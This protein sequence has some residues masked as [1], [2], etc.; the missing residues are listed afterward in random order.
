ME[1][2]R[3]NKK[4]LLMLVIVLAV[5]LVS[6]FFASMIQSAGYKV[7]VTDLR[8]ATNSGYLINEE[9][10]QA[11]TTEVEG[12]VVSGI[13]FMP[14]DASASNKK[15][16]VVL[17]HG[18]LNNRELQL[19][20]A[21]ELAR[22]G[23][24]VLTIDRGGH[25]NNLPTTDTSAM[26]NTSG[27]YDSVKYLYN[28]P[29]VDKTKIGISGH[30]MGGFTT[31][32][33]LMQDASVGIV[34]AGLMQGWDSF[35]GAGADVSVGILKA[36]DDEFF[37]GSEFPNGEP[38][39][40]R[41]YLHSTGA[42]DF[43]G[44][45]YDENSTI[46]IENGGIYVNGQLTTTSDDGSA[47]GQPFRVIYEANEIHPLNHFSTESAG[48]L[49]DFF[50]KAFGTPDGNDFIAGGNQIWW[51][52]EAFSTIGLAAF[53]VLIFPVV[54]LLLTLPCFASLRKK[55]ELDLDADLPSIKKGGLCGITSTVTYFAGGLA[56]MLFGGFILRKCY[57]EW[58]S[59][60][61]PQGTYFPQDTTGSIMGW[62]VIC[63]A[64]ALT[65]MGVMWLVKAIVAKVASSKG[66]ETLAV[67]N[68]FACARIGISD[69]LK[70]IFLAIVVIALLY[71]VVFINWEIW[72]VDFRIWTLD[73]K[74]FMIEIVPAISRY[75]PWFF[76]FYAV[77]AIGNIG[78]R[79]KDLPEWATIAINAFFNAAGVL[80][81][82][83]IQYITF[84]STGVLWQPEMNLGYI[85]VFPLVAVLAIATIISRV[86]YKKTGNVWLG[87]MI[88]AILFTIITCANT[89]ASVVYTW[90]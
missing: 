38:S 78:F 47:V 36:M 31:A 6:S 12:E 50:Y 37:F 40:C 61:F 85:V 75:I 90:A 74:P 43:V 79:L 25:G 24:I 14:K 41:E 62:A 33:T 64:F 49:V 35:M 4:S 63:A 39:I 81:V 32:M 54:S 80:L 68:P 82:I 26:M 65:V 83:L 19:Q 45:S 86:L 73:V 55:E 56:T 16:A 59:R 8:N 42:A 51:I 66:K 67:G 52:K 3:K 21:I 23:F 48:Y 28:L 18:Y 89:A 13:L 20:N 10:G 2:L 88:N 29:E 1:Y 71:L 44:Q 11:T 58:S 9:T 53:F 60:I 17:T 87:A 22:R 70:T 84:R 15:P 5:I 27:M 77:S 46:N 76:A 34:S 57:T 30:S 72:V 69:F 7:R